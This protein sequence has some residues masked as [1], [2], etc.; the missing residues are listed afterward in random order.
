MLSEN[1]ISVVD[2]AVGTDNHNCSTERKKMKNENENEE[3]E[4]VGE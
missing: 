1:A 2:W 4:E 3:E